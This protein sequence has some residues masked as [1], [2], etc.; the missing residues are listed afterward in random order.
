MPI[1]KSRLSDVDI[2]GDVDLHNFLF[3][4]I[5]ECRNKT[6]IVST[7]T[8]IRSMISIGCQQLKSPK[9]TVKYL[10]SHLLRW[11]EICPSIHIVM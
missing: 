2:P 7:R 8:R 3:K 11:F 10:F 5:E 4:D 9:A 6:A 1:L